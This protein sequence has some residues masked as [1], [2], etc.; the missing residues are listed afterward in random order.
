M[1]SFG[2]PD[3]TSFTARIV[4]HDSEA[5]RNIALSGSVGAGESYMT[6]DWSSPDLPLLIRVL[7]RN[8]DV[9]DNIDGGLANIGKLFLQGFHYLNRNTEK[10][11][12]PQHRCPLRPGQR[13]VRII[14]RPHHDVLQRYFSVGDRQH[15]RSLTV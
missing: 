7:A 5:Y 4:I 12:T 2:Q 13:Y 14:S 6:G 15:G 1:Q 9:V 11:L 10:R 8:K 3:A